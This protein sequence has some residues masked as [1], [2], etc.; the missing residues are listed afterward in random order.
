MSY[1][2]PPN[3]EE[4]LE[5]LERFQILDTPPEGVFER[6]GRIAARTFGVNIALITFVD[7]HRQWFKA[8]YGLDLRE[9]SRELSFCAHALV[10][11]GVMVVPDA[12]QD[13]RFA[14]NALVTG[15]P[16]IRFYAGAPLVTSDGYTLGTLCLIDPEP[17]E[18]FDKMEREL[19]RDMA[20]L[21]VDELELRLQNLQTYETQKRYRT[22]LE[23]LSNG[24]MLLGARGEVLVCNEHAARL[25]GREPEEILGSDLFLFRRQF[26]Q[27]DG[28]PLDIDD[29]PALV[30]LR[31]N[32]PV[33]GTTVG[34]F[35]T[36]DKLVWTKVDA[37]PVLGNDA[38]QAV[39]VVFSEVPAPVHDDAKGS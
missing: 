9:T 33:T 25:L 31:T 37:T 34:M 27:D 16:R 6:I 39:S 24:V 22:L 38:P 11:N 18:G 29:H 19:L 4:R 10:H 28:M 13:I 14:G 3:E 36:D 20:G 1:P 23:T 2:L 30:S 7:E 35:Q 17:R 8:C 15:E 21:V 32:R 5:A 26:V 12:A